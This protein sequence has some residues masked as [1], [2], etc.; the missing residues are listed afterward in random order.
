[1]VSFP[2]FGENSS[3]DVFLSQLSLPSRI[4]PWSKASLYE[5]ILGIEAPI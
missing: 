5:G 2:A 3:K 4:S 1:M